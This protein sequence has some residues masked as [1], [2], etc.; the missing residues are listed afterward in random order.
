AWRL[1]TGEPPTHKQC[2]VRKGPPRRVWSPTQ[3]TYVDTLLSSSS[4]TLN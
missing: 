3:I 2:L 1:V 4:W